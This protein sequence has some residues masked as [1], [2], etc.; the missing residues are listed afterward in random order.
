MTVDKSAQAS[1]EISQK[2]EIYK[3][4]VDS[5]ERN[6][7]RRMRINQFYFSIVAALFIAYA[8]MAEGKLLGTAEMIREWSGRSSLPIGATERALATLPL[9][10]LPLFL[11]VIGMSWFSVLLS[12]RALSTAKYQV[13]GDIEKDLPVQPFIQEW[14]YFKRVRKIETTQLE[15]AIPLLFYVAAVAGVLVPILTPR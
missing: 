11:M 3:I 9:W 5:A 14:L 13:I 6:V 7:E 4:F 10:I 8:Y 15:L 12:H 1:S 2:I